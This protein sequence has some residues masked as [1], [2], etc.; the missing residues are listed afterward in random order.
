MGEI[1]DS[2]FSWI[3]GTTSAPKFQHSMGSGVTNELESKDPELFVE[4]WL[5]REHFLF[6]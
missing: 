6:L 4:L 5:Y 1:M 3:C 2:V